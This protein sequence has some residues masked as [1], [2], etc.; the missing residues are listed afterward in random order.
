MGSLAAIVLAYAHYNLGKPLQPRTLLHGVF[1]DWILTSWVGS[2]VDAL[3]VIAVVAGTV[4]P[5]GFQIGRAH[6]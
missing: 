4:G 1:G 2:V 5:I 6:V 3:C